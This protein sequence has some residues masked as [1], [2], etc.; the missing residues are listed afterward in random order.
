MVS[1]YPTNFT[2]QEF[3]RPMQLDKAGLV[4]IDKEATFIRD[5][6]SIQ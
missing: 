5:K 3:E 6:Y 2:L 4:L 1:T